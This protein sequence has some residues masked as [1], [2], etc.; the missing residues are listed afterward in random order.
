MQSR[1][2]FMILS[3]ITDIS[4]AIPSEKDKQEI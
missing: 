3:N 2:E 1:Q 4:S